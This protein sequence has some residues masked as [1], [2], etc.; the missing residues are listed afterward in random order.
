VVPAKKNAQYNKYPGRRLLTSNSVAVAAFCAV[1]FGW[2][3]A[4]LLA[5]A[6]HRKPQALDDTLGGLRK[7]H[8]DPTPRIGGGAI[9]A[10]L[11]MGATV[12]VISS[13]SVGLWLLLLICL[14][15]AF[16]WGLIEDLSKRGAVMVRLALTAAAAALGYIVLDARL[17]VLDVPGLDMLLA[18]NTLSFIFTVFAVTGVAHATNVIDGL[19]GLSG[20]TTL[21]ASVGLAIVAS[22]VGD[23]FVC[24]AAWILAGS[25]LGFLVVNFPRGRIFLGDG[26]AYLVG[27]MIALLSV[28]LVHRNSE[29]SPWLPLVLMA[30]PIWET[31]FSMYRRKTRGHSTG[32]A[33]ALH[34]HTLLYRRVVRWGGFHARGRAATMRNSLASLCLWTIPAAGFPIA[35]MYWNQ[36]S[37]LQI[38]AFSFAALY[39]VAYRALVR[40]QVPAWLVIRAPA[41]LKAEQTPEEADAV[42]SR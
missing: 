28:M 23:S 29:V 17:S 16:V 30:Y 13:G 6:G 19:N 5:I 22:V 10:G 25:I 32:H 34:L 27:L 40:F 33:D 39:V 3:A 4:H 21:L 18:I 8:V 9:A 26:G 7:V 36:S 35:L 14:V 20:F 37:A 15:P 12:S 38:A 11:I 42:A 31:L 2:V 24:S 1:V 41:T